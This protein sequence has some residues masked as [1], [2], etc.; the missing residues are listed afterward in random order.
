LIQLQ[1]FTA[2]DFLRL[3]NW[4]PDAEMM[5]Q[6]A[7]PALQHPLTEQQ[8]HEYVAVQN[9]IPFVVCWQGEAIGHCAITFLENTV[10]LN[11][12]LIGSDALRGKGIGQQLVYAMIAEIKKIAD[13]QLKPIELYVFDWNK[14]AIACYEKC[15]FVQMPNIFR[16]REVNGKKWKAIN[17]VRQKN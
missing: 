7:G 12:I 13:H 3:I 8:L 17:M 9:R 10:M 14:G 2:Q 16:M 1:T 4:I 11:H 6:F 5:M 15:G